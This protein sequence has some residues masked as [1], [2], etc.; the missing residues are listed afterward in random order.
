MNFVRFCELILLSCSEY[1]TATATLLLSLISLYLLSPLA[2]FR[3]SSICRDSWLLSHRKCCSLNTFDIRIRFGQL[4]S[5]QLVLGSS[6][7]RCCLWFRL[8]LVF[9]HLRRWLIIRGRWSH[10]ISWHDS[11][12]LI[13]YC[14]QTV[15]IIEVLDLLTE[16]LVYINHSQ[17]KLVTY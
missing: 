5:L 8:R 15:W 3:I 2:C 7:N 10:C 6:L 14:E 1:S 9:E 16:L 12:V 17:I 11:F 13:D 4:V